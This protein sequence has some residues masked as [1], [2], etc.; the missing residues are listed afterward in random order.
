MRNRARVGIVA[1]MAAVLVGVT[2]TAAYAD[3]YTSSCGAASNDPGGRDCWI[4]FWHDGIAVGDGEFWAYGERLVAIDSYADG[5]GVYVGA[6]W[7]DNGMHYNDYRLTSGANT[8]HTLD[9]SIPEGTSV[10]FTSCQ[11]DN[12]SLLNCRTVTAM[13]W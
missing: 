3:Y 5:R 13:A 8:S 12:G 2:S 9:L 1:A 4:M 10:T 7:Y 6:Q 11:T